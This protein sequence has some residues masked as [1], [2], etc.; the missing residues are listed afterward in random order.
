MTLGYFHGLIPRRCATTLLLAASLSGLPVRN[1]LAQ[2]ADAPPPAAPVA[3][4][5]EPKADVADAPASKAVDPTKTE[6]ATD[7]AKFLLKHASVDEVQEILE[8]FLKRHARPLRVVADKRT[9]SVFVTGDAALIGE[10]RELLEILDKK[11]TGGGRVHDG[12]RAHA[13]GVP[14]S[15]LFTRSSAAPGAKLAVFQLKHAS[16]KDLWETTMALFADDHLDL[17]LDGRT[18]SLLLMASDSVTQKVAEFVKSLDVPVETP[19]I[20]DAANGF[21]GL[22]GIGGAMFSGGAGGALG[23]PAEAIPGKRFVAGGSVIIAIADNGKQVFGYCDRHPRWTP[24]ALP[25]LPNVEVTPVVGGLTAAVN[26]GNNCY[27]YSTTLGTWDT[28]TLPE[29]EVAVPTLSNE[30]ITVHSESKGDYVFK[31]EWAKW[32][33]AAEIKEGKV[34]QHLALRKSIE[35]TTQTRVK[36]FALQHA[37]AANVAQLIEQLFGQR[38]LPGTHASIELILSV[39]E[40][41][42]SVIVRYDPDRVDIEGIEAVINDLD[43]Q[44]PRPAG[45]LPNINTAPPARRPVFSGDIYRL[46]G[47]DFRGAAEQSIADLQK[48]CDQLER[49]SRDLAERLRKP[50]PDPGTGNRLA[51]E[52]RQTVQRAFEARQNLQRAELA[53]FARRLKSIQQSIE[54]RETIREE[55]TDRRVKE[56]LEPNLKWEPTG[57]SSDA[58]DRSQRPVGKQS[59]QH[60]DGPQR[61]VARESGQ[62][63]DGPQRPVARES[64]QHQDGPQRPVAR[65]SGQPSA[66]NRESD[67]TVFIQAVVFDLDE[68]AESVDHSQVQRDAPADLAKELKAFVDAGK[69]DVLSRPQLSTTLGRECMLEIGQEIPVLRGRGV[70]SEVTFKK[71]GDTIAITPR[72]ENGLPILDLEFEFRRV[73]QRAAVTNSETVPFIQ[74]NSGELT[75]E[76]KAYGGNGQVLGPFPSAPKKNRFIHLIVTRAESVAAAP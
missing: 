28:L 11:T 3:P 49:E 63:Q 42:N 62:H 75:V 15:P 5:E 14:Q 12:Y 21:G 1:S 8:F 58:N 9:K 6:N 22:P 19:P 35:K 18:N 24:Q 40:R 29:G 73:A 23:L 20:A 47:F 69:A 46:N 39:D 52:L 74:S 10:A 55:I 72:E 53:E 27:A 43:S 57:F 13:P 33:S 31:N 41:T 36:I 38:K 37:P 32:F 26:Y 56:L 65:E 34:A 30:S 45:A 67:Q 64:G 70:D 66:A 76:M 7:I 44:E 61:P 4:V 16:A 2:E 51:R 68:E 25:P 17:V 48:N 54:M 60:Q 59:G 50:L 71:V